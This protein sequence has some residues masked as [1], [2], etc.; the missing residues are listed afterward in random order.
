MQVDAFGADD[1]RCSLSRKKIKLIEDETSTDRLAIALRA[2]T[3]TKDGLKVVAEHHQGGI[4]M[5]SFWSLLSPE[6]LLSQE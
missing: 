2:V 1:E 5:A 4:T 6:S 3:H